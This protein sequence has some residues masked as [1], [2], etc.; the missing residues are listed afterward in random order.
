MT[1]EITSI[2]PGIVVARPLGPRGLTGPEPEHEWV[3]AHSLRFR[4]PDGS[5][6]ETHDLLGATGPSGSA[7]NF[8]TV[9][10]VASLP[11]AS[12]VNVI[13]TMG[14]YQPGDAG[15]ARYRLKSAPE[16]DRPGDIASADGKRWEIAETVIFA[17][18]FGAVAHQTDAAALAVGAADSTTA[19]LNAIA[20]LRKN[21]DT[22]NDGMTNKVITVYTSGALNFGRGIFNIAAGGIRITQDLNLV[23]KGQGSR[24]KTNFARA[25]TTILVTGT[26]GGH[27]ISAYGNGS[28]GFRQLD[29]DIC[30]A[31]SG[32]TGNVLGLS[33]SPGS[34][35][36][37][38]QIGTFGIRGGTRLQ[39]A[40]SC[41]SVSTDE[42]FNPKECVFDGAQRG[43]KIEDQNRFA[44]FTG[45]VSGTTLTVTAVASGELGT[46]LIIY[47]AGVAFARI[48]ALGTGTGGVGTYTLNASASKSSRTLEADL[49]FGGSNSHI[50]DCVFYDITVKSIEFLG[51]RRRARQ[52]IKNSIV[53]PIS[54][55]TQIGFDLRNVDGFAVN[56]CDFVGSVGNAPTVCWL[57]AE[58]CTG[59]ITSNIFGDGAL[60]ATIQGNLNVTGNTLNGV[61]GFV[62]NGG[63]I[64][65]KGN[66]FALTSG[67]GWAVPA[68]PVVPLF[69]DLGPDWFNGNVSISYEIAS[70]S[71]AKGRIYRSV[72]NDSSV[73]GAI[74][75]APSNVTITSL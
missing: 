11:V 59:E 50:T 54:L 25:A 39:T 4:N 12:G 51:A 27:G 18:M 22:I 9:A 16:A 1:S 56:N 75:G 45:S 46:D 40:R 72:S 65:G 36:E 43:I 13:R 6:G 66:E 35:P 14:Y 41:I 31:T 23:W 42:F 73:N 15:A 48:S 49:D 34:Y 63:I 68:S 32:F 5:W 17:E 52:G 67:K 3:G 60:G 57:W 33:G 21:A 7:Q 8:D 61:G 30:Y 74:N 37:R 10:S 38:C 69:I 20:F 70:G 28:R 26:W 2:N 53:N 62:P 19:V 64:T 58:N 55:N 29:M 44:T 71:T 47:D 24:G